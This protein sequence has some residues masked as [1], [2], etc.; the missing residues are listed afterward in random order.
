MTIPIFN[1]QIINTP[2]GSQAILAALRT[3]AIAQ[4]WTDIEYKTGVYWVNGVGYTT[5]G[6]DYI[7]FWDM[8]STGYGVQDLHYRFEAYPDQG[9]Q[10]TVS[11]LFAAPVIPGNPTYTIA[12]ATHGAFQNQWQDGRWYDYN[13]PNGTMPKMWL[14]GLS[15]RS[16]FFVAQITTDWCIWGG[17]GMLELLPEFRTRANQWQML[18]QG[19]YS[20]N[21]PNSY[22]YNMTTYHTRWGYTMQVAS[23]ADGWKQ[24]Y[25]WER[26]RSVWTDVLRSNCWTNSSAAFDGHFGRLHEVVRYNSFTNKRVA[27]MPTWYYKDN[28]SGLWHVLGTF[29]VVSIVTQGINFGEEIEFGGDT[30]LGFPQT[31][32][33]DT[34]GFAFR[35]A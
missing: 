18:F 24:M 7:D 35:I 15:N 31:R 13:M 23:N 29:P 32:I 21:F 2:N 34:G 33:V 14:F 22:W 6:S 8:K 12:S 3:F 27:V 5:G 19:C 30:Y 9:V 20:D 11:W 26:S 10:T 25:D 28:D 17:F 4:G 1:H 16:L